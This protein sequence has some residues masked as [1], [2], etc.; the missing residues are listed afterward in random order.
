M[1]PPTAKSPLDVE[2][3][4]CGNGKGATACPT[5]KG[6]GVIRVREC[7]QAYVGRLWDVIGLCQFADKGAWPL[8][9]GVL[10]QSDSFL[11]FTSIWRAK[12]AQAQ[13]D[14]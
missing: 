13:N 4:A 3:P 12:L 1:N 6:W 14:G 5:C 2:C 10:D 11:T 7:P 8:A 9:G